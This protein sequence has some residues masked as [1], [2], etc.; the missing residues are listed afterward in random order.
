MT[1]KWG[2]NEGPKA[3]R[4][5]EAEELIAGY[6]SL[7]RP[8]LDGLTLRIPAGQITCLIGPN[9]SGKSTLLKSLSRQLR[10]AGG[11]V[12][13]D[14]ADIATESTRDFARRLAIL[15]QEN[16]APAGLTVEGLVRHGRFPH[17][18][19]LEPASREDDEAIDR[20]LDLTG[21]TT[22]RERR[23]EELSG[24]QRQLVWIAMALAQDTC[25]LLLDEPTTFLDLGHQLQVMRV[26]EKLQRDHGITIVMVMHDVNLA[27]RHA[28][29]LVL[30]KS[31]KI[32]VE[33]PPE[34]VITPPMM[35]T[36]YEVQGHVLKDDQSKA[37][38]FVPDAPA[39]P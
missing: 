13:L 31:G 11:R 38:L 36:A 10:L 2:A 32:L 27:A 16:A 20:A 24:G 7:A 39:A 28:H 33:G 12:L 17:R 9:G 3:Q 5:L 30:L 22:L 29:H 6:A 14:G 1:T 8:V 37:L 35:R 18:G 21:T 25:T 26:V 4:G 15:F 19:F 34:F 23:V